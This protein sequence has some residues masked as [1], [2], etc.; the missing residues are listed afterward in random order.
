MVKL[1]LRTCHQPVEF[2]GSIALQCVEIFEEER[3]VQRRWCDSLT[4]VGIR[5]WV[6]DAFYITQT[7][8]RL[9][10]RQRFVIQLCDRAR[11]ITV[12]SLGVYGHEQVVHTVSANLGR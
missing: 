9:V 3:S 2:G 10:F 12:H 11:Q 5:Q 7:G 1:S 6:V 8:A 4:I